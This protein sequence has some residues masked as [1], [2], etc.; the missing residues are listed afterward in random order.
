[1][2]Y[3]ESLGTLCLYYLIKISVSFQP[4][5]CFGLE[6]SHN[7]SNYKEGYVCHSSVQQRWLG[8]RNQPVEGRSL[9]T[10]GVSLSATAS[11]RLLPHIE[12]LR[13][14]EGEDAEKLQ[15]CF[16]PGVIGLRINKEGE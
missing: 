3:P 13:P 1:M 7:E 2:V 11:Y 8:G 16:S 5:E 4:F 12:L 10:H 6:N 15:R 9:C 14:V